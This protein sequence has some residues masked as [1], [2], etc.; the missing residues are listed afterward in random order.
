M[1]FFRSKDVFISSVSDSASFVNS[2]KEVY[3]NELNMT[4]QFVGVFNNTE[5]K[6]WLP[7][8][9]R[10]KWQV[11]HKIARVHYFINLQYIS[12]HFQL[13]L[14]TVPQAS[15]LPDMKMRNWPKYLQKLAKIGHFKTWK[16]PQIGQKYLVFQPLIYAF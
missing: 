3:Y 10:N 13:N 5:H 1:Y 6:L 4:N 2:Y 12:W 9:I 15:G 11:L 16:W 8:S 14:T 7:S